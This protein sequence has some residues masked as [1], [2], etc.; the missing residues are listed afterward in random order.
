MDYSDVER[1]RRSMADMKGEKV[2]LHAIGDRNRVTRAVGVL[3]G[4]YPDVFTVHVNREG[5]SQRYSYTYSE[6]ITKNVMIARANASSA[7]DLQA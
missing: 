5:Y 3:D 1:I 2:N 6:V 7:T 4:V